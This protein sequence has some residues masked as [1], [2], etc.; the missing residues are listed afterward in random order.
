[1]SSR[2]MCIIWY[3]DVIVGVKLHPTRMCILKMFSSLKTYCL[4]LH[5][6]KHKIQFYNFS[7]QTAE[8]FISIHT[9]NVMF[10]IGKRTYFLFININLVIFL[11]SKWLTFTFRY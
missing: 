6:H 4:T 11:V 2:A 7:L 8:S 3:H 10:K 1:M 9:E 5:S